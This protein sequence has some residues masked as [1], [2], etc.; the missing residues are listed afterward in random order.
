MYKVVPLFDEQGDVVVLIR[1]K[2][3][4]YFLYETFEEALLYRE[5]L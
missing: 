4:G 3:N 2:A 1:R 5:L